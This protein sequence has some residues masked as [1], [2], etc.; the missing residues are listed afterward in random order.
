MNK[1][2]Q[3]TEILNRLQEP[4]LVID[5]A[6][7]IRYANPAAVAVT[8]RELLEILGCRCHELTHGHPEPCF[9]MG[10]ACPVREVF[11]TGERVSVIHEHLD[12][13]GGKR[14]E[15][16]VATPLRTENGEVTLVIEELRD[17]TA[18]LRTPEIA[19]ALMSEVKVLRGILPICSSCKR[20]RNSGGG[21]EP[22]E[23]YLGRNSEAGFTH[24]YCPSCADRI[25]A[26]LGREE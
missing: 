10:E 14:W 6:W 24:G 23:H 3:D 12:P 26:D 22:L 18:L 1:K 20:I 8:R 5:R 19:Q 15:Q 7:T 17:I 9:R 13:D 16:I 21:W 11:A 4:V 2:T 25:L